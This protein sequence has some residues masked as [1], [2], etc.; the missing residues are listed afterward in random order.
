MIQSE[1][2]TRMIGDDFE[3]PSLPFY[4]CP[5]NE[6]NFANMFQPEFGTTY[7]IILS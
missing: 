2:D 3:S 4:Q 7:N 5:M 6:G 1:G